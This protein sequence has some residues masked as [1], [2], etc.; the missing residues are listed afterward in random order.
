[1]KVSELISKLQMLDQNA[2]IKVV[3]PIEGRPYGGGILKELSDISETFDQ[4]INN[5]F[6]SIHLSEFKA[7]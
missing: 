1:M 7:E 3:V 4:D 5:M 6:Y 2:T